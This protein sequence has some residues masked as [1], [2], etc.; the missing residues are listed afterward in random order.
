M[1]LILHTRATCPARLILLE[2]IALI[3]FGETYKLMKLL[4]MQSSPFSTTSSLLGPNLLLRR[5]PQSV[6]FP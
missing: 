6:F 5:H 1:H 4:L 2:F 3:I